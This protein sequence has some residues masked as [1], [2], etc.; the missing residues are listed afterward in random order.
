MQQTNRPGLRSYQ[1]RSLPPQKYSEGTGVNYRQFQDDEAD[2]AAMQKA[3]DAE[4]WANV[5]RVGGSVVGTGLG[6]VAGGLIGGLP[7]AGVGVIPGALAGAGIGGTI[8]TGIGKMAGDAISKG[9]QEGL[10]EMRKRKMKEEAMM[11][12]LAGMNNF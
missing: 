10:D 4:G 8:G 11:M 9:G 1:R 7:T 3:S 2:E 12:A 5:A 6:A